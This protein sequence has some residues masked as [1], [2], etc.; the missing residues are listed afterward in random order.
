MRKADTEMAEVGSEMTGAA[1]L[2]GDDAPTCP[3]CF[4]AL[5]ETLSV[6]M[7]EATAGGEAFTVKI[8]Y[9]TR[10]GVALGAVN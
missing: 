10:C 1:G 3:N 9:C 5:D 7:L 8:A 4:A 6:R 2:P